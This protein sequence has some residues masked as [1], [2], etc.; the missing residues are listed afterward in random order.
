MGKRWLYPELLI[1]LILIV[2]CSAIP[3]ENLLPNQPAIKK[4]SQLTAF[5]WDDREIFSQ[6][7]SQSGQQYLD[8]LP[9]A[10]VYHI[11]LTIPEK[12]TEPL[13]G[14]MEVR[15]FN[16][17]SHPLEEIYFRLFPNY[18]T[19]FLSV[20]DIEVDGQSVEPLLESHQTALRVDLAQPLTPGGSAIVK[21][22]FVLQL[23][24]TMSGNY[25]LLGYFDDVLVL[26]TFY[27]MIP[28]YDQNGWYVHYPYKNGDLTYTDASFYLVEI[29]APDDFILASSGSV[30]EKSVYDGQ[31]CL[32]IASGPA[33]D[34]YLA[35]S[36]EF[37]VLTNQV[38]GI[39]INSYA[40][41]GSS[42]MQEL[43]LNFS[44]QALHI[45]ND[46][47]GGYPYQEFDV[48]SSPMQALGIE[49]P[50][51]SG[52]FLGLYE[53]NGST[54]GVENRIMLETVI[55]HEVGHQ[56]FY[57]LVGN[58]QQSEPWVDEA[59][60]QYITYQ[61]I[62]QQYGKGAGSGLV[63]NWKDR[64]EEVESEKVPIGLVAGDYGDNAYSP[65]VYGR[66]PLFYL[67]LEEQL[68]EEALLRAL[69]NYAHEYSWKVANTEDLRASLEA[70]CS[71]NLTEIFEEW[72]YPV[73]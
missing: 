38:N 67:Q 4:E 43:A 34:F 56:W 11:S 30:V 9:E 23:P 60:T 31:Q 13:T 22:E 6:T 44:G 3:E 53:E 70:T 21:M 42:T 61:Y 54:H 33:R 51:I 19:G 29:S 25:G 46:L 37:E 47:F 15:Y 27:P 39:I 2:S 57:N 63:Q 52:I 5:A 45:F 18:Y 59:L 16:Q 1:L 62:V 32:L 35:G 50:G 12:L 17:E 64:W 55:A 8:T 71:C 66:G 36:P 24:E 65:I 48:I 10:S 7:L 68:G 69:K 28:A 20:E 40:L 26:D 72:I 58:N 49:Y 73:E 14:S 41:A